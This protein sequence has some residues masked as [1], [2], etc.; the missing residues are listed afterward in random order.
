MFVYPDERWIG[1]KLSTQPAY[2]LAHFQRGSGFGSLPGLLK[3]PQPNHWEWWKMVQAELVPAS[4]GHTP[5]PFCTVHLGPYSG[6]HHFRRL[7]LAGH[8]CPRK[9]IRTISTPERTS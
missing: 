8:G 3:S 6:S 7:I 9:G 2:A 5:R 4:P 1:C